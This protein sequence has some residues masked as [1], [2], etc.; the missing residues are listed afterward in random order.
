MNQPIKIHTKPTKLLVFDNPHFW[1]KHL[2]WTKGDLTLILITL[3]TEYG[4]VRNIVSK[5]YVQGGGGGQDRIDLFVW[6]PLP[7]QI[8]L[9]CG[10]KCVK[11]IMGI[12][13]IV[14]V[15]REQY[16]LWHVQM[17]D[18]LRTRTTKQSTLFIKELM[19]TRTL[20]ALPFPT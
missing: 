15:C 17:N 2:C 20:P 12:S 8:F 18:T 16:G 10:L 4:I 3:G 19:S 9:Y 5:I 14:L 6:V 7:R 1:T 13:Y 11:I